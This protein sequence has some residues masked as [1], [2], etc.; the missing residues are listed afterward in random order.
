ML[1][2]AFKVNNIFRKVHIIIIKHQDMDQTATF[3]IY[4]ATIFILSLAGAYLPHAVKMSDKHTHLM[5]SL[6]TGIFVGVL[7][8]MLLPEAVHESIE[9]GFTGIQIMAAVMAGFICVLVFDIFLKHRVKP[10]CE[11]DECVDHHS[12]DITSMSAFVGLAVHACFDGLAL[13]AAFIVGNEVG[14]MMLLALCI[15]KVV[16]VFSLSSTFLLSSKKDSAMKYLL[17]FCL[18]T[19]ITAFASYFFLGS[20]D[21]SW[22]GIAFAV[23]AGIFLFVTMCNMIPEA[24]HRKDLDIK[25][26]ALL[27]LGISVVILVA[28]FSA[29][30][31]GH[32]H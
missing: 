6:S 27:L 31:G 16:A 24:F 14:L 12:H 9:A 28:L 19:P 15:H 4:V 23:S 5:I 26:L 7:F 21:I 32:V 2:I 3:C 22:M 20:I 8:L 11:C 1:Q 10:D 13:G 25:S 17:V 30:F 18:I 29:H